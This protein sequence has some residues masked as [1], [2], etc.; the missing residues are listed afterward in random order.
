MANSPGNTSLRQQ[1]WDKEFWKD[2]MDGLYF[3]GRQMIGES[4]NSV[5]YVKNDLRKSKGSTINM[6]LSKK[7]T[8][9]GVVG[10]AEL[11]G[12]EEKLNYYNDSVVID[13]IRNAVR[14]DGELDEQ[15]AAQDLFKDAKEKGSV[16][17]QEF[18]EN[19]IFMKAAGINNTLLRRIDDTT[20]YSGRATWSNSPDLVPAADE[21][22]GKG[23]RYICTDASGID[24]LEATDILTTT[25]I[26]RARVKAELASPKIRP[27]RVDGQNFYVMFIHPWQAADLKT[28][29]GSLWAQAQRD[30]QERGAKNPIFTGALGVWDGVILHAH[31]YVPT[32][33]GT[34]D[35]SGTAKFNTAGTA[36]ANGVR[37]FR[38]LLCGQQAVCMANASKLGSGAAPSYVRIRDFDYGDK[39]GAG[40]GYIGG[41]QKPTYNSLDYGVI[42]VDTG[43]TELG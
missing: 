3:M 12:N 14:L 1:L 19:Q 43:A 30:A 35:G 40:V 32:A 8:G 20:V 5:V 24:S 9:D 28:A 2:V 26:T 6:G 27:I 34:A 15:M 11:E 37:C 41:I 4:E 31:E 13:Q 23:L 17:M 36:V 25:F 29:S 39:R 10:N 38:S 21:A 33:K 7:M 22:A 16:W 18:L 42:T